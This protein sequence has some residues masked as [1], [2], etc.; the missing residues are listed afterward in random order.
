[1][2]RAKRKVIKG[3]GIASGI[4]LGTARVILPGERKVPEVAVPASS[5]PDEI[6]ALEHAVSRTVAELTNLRDAA[7]KKIGGPVAKIF[8]AQLLIASD[9]DFLQRVKDN[10]A[11]NR[12]NAAFVYNSQVQQSIQPLRRSPDP[13]LRQMAQDVESVA[14]RVLTFLGSSREEPHARFPADT[15]LVSKSFTPGEILNFRNLK[16][17]GFLV[18]EGGV[19]SHM[20]LIARSLM[21]P[22]VVAQHIWIDVENDSRVIIDGTNGVAI[23]NPT[24]T[25]WNEYQKRKKRQGP[26][27]ITRIKKLA[28]IPPETAD[29]QPVNIAANLE[30]PGPVEDILAE[31]KIPVGLYRTEFIYLERDRF[32]DEDVQ[33]EYYSRIAEKFAP[34]P[35]VLRT[36]DLGSDKFGTNGS[37]YGEDNP[38][39]GWRGIRSMLEMS[40]VFK[41]QIRAILRASASKNLKIL[42]PMISDLSEVERA[43][44]LIRQV[45][46]ELRRQDIPFDNDIEV[47]IMIEV[48]SAA[49]LADQLVKKVDFLSI[50]TNDLT[51]Y[52]MSADRNNARVASLYSPFHPSVLHLVKL[53]VD[54]A[55][56]HGKPVTICGEVAGDLLALPLF[57]GLGIDQL[58][59]NPSRIVDICRLVSKIDS[60]LVRHLVGAVMDSTSE[61]SVTRKL[62]SFKT[63]LEKK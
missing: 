30:L 14:N 58:S 56:R 16:V 13:Y 39:L 40:N 28:K 50:G 17:I 48:P 37:G 29:G 32:P 55:K 52:T 3:T 7:V 10:I 23:V 59:M 60:S 6:G 21:V 51:Q 26:A 24:A 25:D 42:L 43:R 27:L 63:A 12:R 11:E 54:A 8:D 44:K 33:Y 19:N 36:F 9:F 4:V 45:Q 5:V 22:V 57:I 18:S 1:M 38:A 49:L 46:L 47:G 53:T 20:A 41:T 2:V 61:A 35:V 62:Q 34:T 31:R 15:I